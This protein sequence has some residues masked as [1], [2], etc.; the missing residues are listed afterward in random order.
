MPTGDRC[1]ACGAPMASDQ[2]YCVECGERRGAARFALPAPGPAV[3]SAAMSRRVRHRPRMSPSATLIAGVGTLLLAMGI[4]VLI[5]HLGNGSTQRAAAAPSV[6]VTVGAGGGGVNTNASAG[7]SG[8][9]DSSASSK[10]HKSS[11]K[12]KSTTATTAVKTVQA[13][14]PPTVTIGAKGS[15]AGYQHG[16]FTGN[17]F[18]P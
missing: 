5:G 11:K 4:G 6:H 7:T 12:A 14:P 9:T 18:G 15:G 17:F 16:H 3:D 13:P 8:A 1:S 10:S 2:R